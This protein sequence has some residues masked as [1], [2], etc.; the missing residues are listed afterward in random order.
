M[1][2]PNGIWISD[3]APAKH[4]GPALFLDRDGVIVREVDYLSRPEDV[5]IENG[6]IELF[7]WA[8]ERGLALVTI[9]NQSGVARGRFGWPDFEAV[10]AEIA[11]QLSAHGVGVDLVVACA[12][13]EEHTPDF[14]AEHARWRKPGPAM[15]ELA[16]EK[17][18]CDLASSLMIGDKASDIEAARNAGLKAAIHVLTGHGKEERAAALKLA[19]PDFAVHV[20]ND[21]VDA[22]ALLDAQSFG[23]TSS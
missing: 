4:R 6:A 22:R 16:T 17:L 19:R 13:H 15:I 10:E 12:F 1:L 18:G 11:R 8:R 9:T 5:V 23:R 21:L 14:D 2:L 7:R 20:A 3:P